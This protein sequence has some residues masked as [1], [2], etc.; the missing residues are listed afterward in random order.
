VTYGIISI[1]IVQ[2]IVCSQGVTQMF[3]FAV[4]LNATRRAFY[5]GMAMVVAAQS[6]A[7]GI[8][9]YLA[10]LI[11]HVSHGWGVR[12]AFFDP[13]GVTHSNNAVQILVYAVPMLLFSYIGVFTGVVAKR[14]GGNG[15]FTLSALATLVLGGAAVLI[16][17]ADSWSAVGDWFVSQ[18]AFTLTVGWVL[19]PVAALAAG[20]YGLI[21]RATP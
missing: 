3:S 14:W 16:T 20:A 21:R 17:W 8:L 11:E 4:G 19:L 13:V 9:L 10:K 15:I 12:L 6:F 7:Y 2:L 1:Y 18:P 5:L